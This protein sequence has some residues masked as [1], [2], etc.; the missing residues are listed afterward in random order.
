MGATT[1]YAGELKGKNG[2]YFCFDSYLG[3]E[4]MEFV[5]SS[6]PALLMRGEGIERLIELER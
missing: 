4:E 5:S 3:R 2:V 1:L 6:L